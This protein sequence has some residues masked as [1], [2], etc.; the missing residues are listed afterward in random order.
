MDHYFRELLERSQNE[1]FFRLGVTFGGT[2][3]KVSVRAILKPVNCI[4]YLVLVGKAGTH[5]SFN[6]VV[7]FQTCA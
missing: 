4:V 5:L 1:Y 7:D 3:N 2:G 6:S